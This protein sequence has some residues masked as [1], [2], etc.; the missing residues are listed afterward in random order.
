MS[1]PLS[2]ALAELQAVTDKLTAAATRMERA[3]TGTD[4]EVIGTA[5]A[6]EVRATF[7]G[8][9]AL[10]DLHIGQQYLQRASTASVGDAVRD[11]I[12]QAQR[13][14]SDRQ[15]QIQDVLRGVEAQLTTKGEA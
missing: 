7:T 9:G 10:V 14:V 5:G 1:D 4:D 13:E 2:G 11:A 15:Q 3:R 12:R 6:G 8:A